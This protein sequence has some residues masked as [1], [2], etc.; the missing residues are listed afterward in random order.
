MSKKTTDIVA[1]LTPIGL[2]LA[3]IFGDRENARF[4]LNQ[5]LVLV[6]A[7]L[8]LGVAERIIGWLPLVGWLVGLVTAILGI[9][10]FVLWIMGFASAIQGTEKPVPIL[11]DI[12]LL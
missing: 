3:F 7:E 4:H 11:G 9:V 5:A 8:I 12:K 2:I 1:Y 10:L 6:L